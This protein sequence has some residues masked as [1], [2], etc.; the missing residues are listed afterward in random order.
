MSGT[1]LW[2]VGLLVGIVTPACL[3]WTPDPDDDDDATDDDA[4]DDDDTTDDDDVG[5]DDDDAADDDD[6]VDDDDVPPPDEAL[7]ADGV[8]MVLTFDS[9]NEASEFAF[10][11]GLFNNERLVPSAEEALLEVALG[12]PTPL[13]Y[14][15]ALVPRVITDAGGYTLDPAAIDGVT[16]TTSA[17]SNLSEAV[18]WRSSDGNAAAPEVGD[19]WTV[20]VRAV[21]SYGGEWAGPVYQA[22]AELLAE[23]QRGTRVYVPLALDI[24]L[25]ALDGGCDGCDDVVLFQGPEG[26]PSVAYSMAGTTFTLAPSDLPIELLESGGVN[27][28]HYRARRERV[29]LDDG[30]ELLLVSARSVVLQAIFLAPG[31]G[32]LSAPGPIPYSAQSFDVQIEGATLPVSGASFTVGG[33]EA[34]FES[35]SPTEG[36]LF[37]E[38]PLTSVGLVAL[39]ALDEEGSQIGVGEIEVELPV[40]ACDLTELEPNGL[41]NEAHFFT[42]GIVA[43][44]SLDP[45]GDTDHYTFNASAGSEYTF[46]TWAARLGD[47]T[48]T[49]IQ[50][51]NSSGTVLVENDDGID[52]LDS[53]LSWTALSGGQF[54]LRV[55]HY[56]NG[57]GPGHDYQMTTSVFP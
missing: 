39:E 27:M 22:R 5:P 6:V 13:A 20:E 2:V 11:G 45:A 16:V 46:E 36:T 40:F 48:D 47:P 49:M 30:R 37:L 43:C 21:G 54:Y 35:I 56:N 51:L 8:L 1:R 24:S 25:E 3:T 23:R 41:L 10:V 44:G 55:L 50:L 17:V 26:G 19:S 7:E 57:G 38:F 52:T 12:Q 31:V 9:L 4:T 42:A 33:Q 14:P 34:G 53:L 28:V 29:T 15:G 18:I 32:F